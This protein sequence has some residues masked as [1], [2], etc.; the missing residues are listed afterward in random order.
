VGRT[1]I[2]D[3]QVFRKAPHDFSCLL[4]RVGRGQCMR[5]SERYLASENETQAHQQQAGNFEV[6]RGENEPFDLRRQFYN[7]GMIDQGP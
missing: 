4:E 2:F 3:I 7:K 5:C 1:R 6:R